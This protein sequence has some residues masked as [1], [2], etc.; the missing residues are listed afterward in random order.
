MAASLHTVSH[1][2]QL[3]WN[4]VLCSVTVCVFHPVVLLFSICSQQVTVCMQQNKDV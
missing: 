3:T 2:E 4:C 1:L